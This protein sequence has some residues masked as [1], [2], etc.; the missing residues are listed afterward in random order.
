MP[1]QTIDAFR[2]HGVVRCTIDA[3]YDAAL[4]S[5]AD[6]ESVGISLKEI[7]DELTRDGV[8]AFIKS[9]ATINTTTAAK[10]EKIR[11]KASAA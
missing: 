10:A 4:K 2:D 6:L 11:Q 5:L 3:D 8:D 7:T 9:F 1:P